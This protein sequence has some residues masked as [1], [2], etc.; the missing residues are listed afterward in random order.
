M[1]DSDGKKDN[2]PRS[3]RSTRPAG[4]G[5]EV[6]VA[7]PST[8]TAARRPLPSSHDGPRRCARGP[9]LLSID[10]AVERR[11][12]DEARERVVALL[13]DAHADELRRGR[14]SPLDAHDIDAVRVYVEIASRVL[15]V[16]AAGFQELGRAAVDRELAPFVKTLV[17]PGSLPEVL[18]RCVSILARLLDF[19]VWTLVRATS[20]IGRIRVDDLGLVSPLLR[21]W[22]L[23]VIE[24]IVRRSVSP[25]AEVVEIGP[26]EAGAS[27]FE[28]EVFL[29]AGAKGRETAS[30]F[31]TGSLP[32]SR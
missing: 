30:G 10:A 27:V 19:G 17:L 13:P 1:A 5:Y 31:S 18:R 28:I 22:Y 24:G 3:R 32:S 15:G 26:S 7:P 4:R 9:V 14:P 29:D 8:P 12:G 21:A 6:G 16:D 2:E 20:E 25:D 23:G 11:F